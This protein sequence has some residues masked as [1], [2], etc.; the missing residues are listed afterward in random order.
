MLL[1]LT[2]CSE[3]LRGVAVILSSPPCSQPPQF[4]VHGFLIEP[5]RVE[6]AT[7]PFQ[8]F[9]VPGMVS[10]AYRPHEVRVGPGTNVA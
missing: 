6:L 10:V 1:D 7:Y 9:F 3:G 5:L 8:Q 4:G 2:G